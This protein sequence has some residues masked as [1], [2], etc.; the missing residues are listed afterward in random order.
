[1]SAAELD[2][3]FA[4]EHELRYRPVNA[5]IDLD[6]IQS[7]RRQCRD[8]HGDCCNDRYSE[9]LAQHL[10]E[11]PLIDTED[12]CL[13]TRTSDTSFV[14]LSYVWGD[15]PVFKTT[16]SNLGGLQQPGALS[17]EDT[18]LSVPNTI[19]DA[20]HLVRQLGE[21]YL[22]VDCPCIVQDAGSDNMDNMLRA[23][24]HIYAS[25]EFTIAAAAGIDANY[26]LRGTGAVSRERHFDSFFSPMELV[27]AEGYPDYTYWAGRGWTF[28]ESLFSRRLLIFGEVVSWL[29]GR[30]VE[31]ECFEGRHD[32][33]NTSS[34]WPTE[35]PH[36]GVPMGMMSLIPKLSSLGRWGNLIQEYS[37]RTLTYQ[38]DFV[39]AFAGATEVIRKTFA[40]GTLHGLPVFFFDIAL[41][42][43][44]SGPLLRRP[45]QPSWSWVGWRGSIDCL[46]AWDPFY[47]RLFR[48]TGEPS[49]WMDGARLRRTA[50][51]RLNAVTGQPTREVVGLN[52]FYEF[53]SMREMGVASL[54][55]R[56][57]RHE[58]AHGHFYTTDQNPGTRYSYPHPTADSYPEMSFEL[59]SPVLLCTAPCATLHFEV[60]LEHNGLVAARAS[61]TQIQISILFW[62]IDIAACQPGAECHLVAISQAEA[63]NSLQLHEWFMDRLCG[64]FDESNPPPDDWLS[65]VSNIGFYNILWIEQEGDIAY[66]KALGLVSKREF[67]ALEAE[68][69]T[70][71]LG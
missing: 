68:V 56:W 67:D 48:T 40:G 59:A 42:W 69:R 19:R 47:A 18:S 24:A 41:L 64:P 35:R 32:E 58:H 50:E 25:A 70:V 26:G 4:H 65:D 29:C 37:A 17:Q 44:P 36:L 66:R 28:Q 49:D 45:E 51:Y 9:P 34:M 2:D 43:Q 11:L 22:W 39:G 21:R 6:V 3:G 61:D 60:I 14:A 63:V 52:D 8:S 1:M 27:R 13:V 55:E 33:Q 23:M 16:I 62:A 30:V 12:S 57:Q 53:A 10:E 7:W 5:I 54:P 15:V 46:H 20:I 71:K 31:L 38:R